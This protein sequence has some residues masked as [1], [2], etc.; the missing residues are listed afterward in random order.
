LARGR[1]ADAQLALN[2]VHLGSRRTPLFVA[3]AVE[4]ARAAADPRQ[5]ELARSV[6]AEVQRDLWSPL[7]WRLGRAPA[8]ELWPSKRSGSLDI[9]ILE[10]PDDGV[11][12]ETRLDGRVIGLATVKT[13]DRLKLNA[14]IDPIPHRL[15]LL[16]LTTAEVVPGVV[17]AL[18]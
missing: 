16:P 11:V 12:V 9:E 1:V 3:T 14:E 5:L 4:V 17:R 2:Q 10:A 8:L 6:Q 13:G 18:P 7:D 15:E